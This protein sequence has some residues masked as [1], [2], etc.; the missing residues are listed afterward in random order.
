MYSLIIVEDET[1]IREGIM[2]LFPWE[3]TGFSIEGGFADGKQALDYLLNNPVD[4]VLTDVRIEAARQYLATTN[5]SIGEIAHQ[6]GYGS[7]NY[8]S[9]V[10]RQETG[11]SPNEYRAQPGRQGDPV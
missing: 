2:N 6:T 5:L 4:V 1:K 11:A 9:K 10:F 8:F 3:S 7:A